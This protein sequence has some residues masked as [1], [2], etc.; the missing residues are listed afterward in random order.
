MADSI[1]ARNY[2][3]SVEINDGSDLEDYFN[4][5]M[6]EENR[7]HDKNSDFNNKKESFCFCSKF[8]KEILQLGEN[9]K[10]FYREH[11]EV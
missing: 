7:V 9:L 11:K 5:N 6:M 4:S 2:A 8:C 1:N 10:N 3:E